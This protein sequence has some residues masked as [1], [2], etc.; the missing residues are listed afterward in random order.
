[1][2]LFSQNQSGS[3]MVSLQGNLFDIFIVKMADQLNKEIQRFLCNDITLG[4]LL[5]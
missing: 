1:M 5:K 2:V 4:M 3:S